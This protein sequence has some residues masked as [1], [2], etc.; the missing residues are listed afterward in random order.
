MKTVGII[1]AG[2][3][4]C[5][6]A[7]ELSNKGF[8]VTV[9]DRAKDILTGAST[10][11][12]LRHHQGFHYPRSKET[13]EEIKNAKDSFEKEFGECVSKSFDNFYGVSKVNS[14][15]TPE[16][17][18]KFC[19]EFKLEYKIAWPEEKYMDRSNIG[20][21]VKTTEK[22]YDPEILKGLIFKKIGNTDIELK[23]NSKIIGCSINEKTKTL[24][25]SHQ[26]RTYEKDF[27]YV[28]NATYSNFNQFN[29]WLGLKR[30]TLLYELM[31]LLEI[32]LPDNK[33][34]GLT[35]MDGGFSSILPRGEKETFTLGH[36]DAS[37]LK[38]ETSEDIDTINMALENTRSNRAEI[39]RKGVEDFPFLKD[40]Q[41]IKSLFITRVVKANVDDT[42]E[43]PSE[44]T[45]YGNGIYSIFAGKIITSVNIAKEVTNKILEN[46]LELNKNP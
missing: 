25:I 5:A 39:M 46:D 21:C 23:L 19:D 28:I 6:V 7:L 43:R 17:F 41:V 11:N 38:A 15:T 40:A 1:G 14:K 34:I 10:L 44:I 31:E 20:I 45:E 2:I 13:V 33:K 35:I 30:K 24:K 12:H 3:F 22:V 37:V 26:N 8:K 29:K 36:V 27:D 4:G 18:I 42:D 32:S 9:F 16:D